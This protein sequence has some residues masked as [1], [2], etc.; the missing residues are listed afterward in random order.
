MSGRRLVFANGEYYHVFN[1]GVARQ[2]IFSSQK[3][4]AQALLTLTYY[5]FVKPPIK[6]SRYKDFSLDIR[7]R[8]IL[9]LQKTNDV[10]IELIAFAFM[11]NHVHFLFKQVVDKGVARFM[12]QFQNSY[13]RYYNTRHERIGP[14]FQGVFKAV[15]IET[16]EQLLHLSRYI[17]LNPLVS[18]VIK[19][20]EF[21]TY[22]WSSF[23]DYLKGRSPFVT[24]SPVLDSFKTTQK[25]K[26]FVLDQVDYAKRL[27]EIKHLALD[28]R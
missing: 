27:E 10:L 17:H 14:V 8:I 7:S 12:S 9:E 16:Q 11:P 20:E 15:H 3:D 2:P 1:R 24:L 26:Q 25:Y 22:P 6:L 19:N 13:T 28:D 5:L 23:S 4:Y 18:Y 21:L